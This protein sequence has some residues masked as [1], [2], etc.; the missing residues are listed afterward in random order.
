MSSRIFRQWGRA[1][2]PTCN[3]WS[4]WTKAEK[5]TEGN[6]HREDP[7]GS[8]VALGNGCQTGQVMLKN[9]APNQQMIGATRN[10]PQTSTEGEDGSL[11]VLF[12]G[13]ADAKPNAVEQSSQPAD[14]RNNWIKAERSTEGEDE[15][16]QLR[17]VVGTGK[18]PE[19]TSD[20]D[21]EVLV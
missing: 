8:K 2:L 19:V 14:G 7:W 4:N 15:L 1:D 20:G 9:R 3:G 18:D 10:E 12:P 5:S 11:K 6:D 17:L 16:L 21:I 13:L